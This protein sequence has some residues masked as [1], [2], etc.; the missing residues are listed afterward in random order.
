M[1]EL[2]IRY[3]KGQLE[4]QKIIEKDIGLQTI[5]EWH[6]EPYFLDIFLPEL[7]KAV[8]YDGWGHG[9]NRDKKRD[10]EI[11]E[12]YGIEILRIKTLKDPMLLD[13]LKE[14]LK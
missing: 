10:K 1:K 13:M 14:F 11:L 2:S 12:K 3:T 6:V 7:N 5:L 8:E 4:L 9:K